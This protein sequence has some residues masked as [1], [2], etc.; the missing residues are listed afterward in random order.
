VAA[1]RWTLTNLYRPGDSLHL[2]H[3]VPDAASQPA[4]SGSLFYP[5]NDPLDEADALTH[6]A[7]EFIAAEFVALAAR[8]GVEVTV[9]LLKDSRH[10]HVGRA[11]CRKAEELGAAPL[12]LAT[13]HKS[14]WA[15]M[16]LGSVSKFCAANCK[17]PVL[18]VHPD[19]SQVQW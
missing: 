8:R 1:F 6:Q 9:I 4:A 2:L 12:V 16:L 17:Q 14:Y 5:P 13:H 15:E 3:V 19:H 11:V 7:E 18:L 10:K